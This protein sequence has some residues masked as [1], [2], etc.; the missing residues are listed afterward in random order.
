MIFV[1]STD[2]E[3]PEVDVAQLHGLIWKKDVDIK[4]L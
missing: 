3:D 4:E 2:D 1:F